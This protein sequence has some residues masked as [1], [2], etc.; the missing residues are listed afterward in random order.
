M[1]EDW[2]VYVHTNKINDKRYVGI[3]SVK[4]QAAISGNLHN[5]QNNTDLTGEYEDWLCN[6]IALKFS[7]L[8]QK[9]A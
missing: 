2:K 7:P 6:I 5:N 8:A 1:N 4:A 3:I 9:C